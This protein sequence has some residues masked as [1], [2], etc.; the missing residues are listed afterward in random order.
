MAKGF[1]FK[2]ME[3]LKLWCGWRKIYKNLMDFAGHE[4]VKLC[5]ISQ[6]L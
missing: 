4:V 1:R 6:N 2:G 3:L 5:K